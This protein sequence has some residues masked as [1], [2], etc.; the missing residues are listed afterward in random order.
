MSD[1]RC[2]AAILV[3]EDDVAIRESI[4]EALEDNEF[5]SIEVGNGQEALARLRAGPT[6]PCVILLDIMMPEMD[7]WQFRALQRQDPTLSSIPVVV[8]T[9]HVNIA[10]V[11]KG[12]APDACLSKPIQLANLVAIVE[13]FCRRTSEP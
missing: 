1:H 2:E 3:V 5:L 12:M 11:E 10:E 6:K 8:I 9:A 7:G 4:A 13:R